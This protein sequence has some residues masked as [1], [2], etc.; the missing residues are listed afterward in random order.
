MKIPVTNAAVSLV[1]QVIF[2]YGAMWI[3]DLHIYAV[4]LA[5]MFYAFLM[6]ILNGQAVIRYSDAKQD[7]HRTYVVPFEASVL[8]G[9]VVF[10]TYR[11]LHALTNSNAVSCVFGIVFGGFSY[12]I[13]IFLMKGITESELRRMPKGDLLISFAK[14][15]HLL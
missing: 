5:N 14:R 1:L 2:L 9:V 12:F 8:M 7:I 6:C 4:V 3:L 15:L 13:L 11:F 10:F